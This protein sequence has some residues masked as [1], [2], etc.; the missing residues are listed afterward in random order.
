MRKTGISQLILHLVISSL[1][2]NAALSNLG[3]SVSI[4]CPSFKTYGTFTLLSEI[5]GN[6]WA[7]ACQR[8][9]PPTGKCHFISLIARGMSKDQSKFNEGDGIGFPQDEE[10]MQIL[11]NSGTIQHVNK[12]LLN[13]CY[14]PNTSRILHHGGNQAP[15]NRIILALRFHAMLKF[16][17]LLLFIISEC[18]PSSRV[19]IIKFDGKG[20][21]I[22]LKV[23]HSEEGQKRRWWGRLPQS[24]DYIIQTLCPLSPSLTVHM[25]CFILC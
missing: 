11:L 23:V 25:C 2:S 22:F 24:E 21:I 16:S 15:R 6:P 20:A 12:P 17:E 8:D 10:R 5:Y 3:P 18:L 1:D 9:S 7:L 4:S 19:L 14:A 13:A